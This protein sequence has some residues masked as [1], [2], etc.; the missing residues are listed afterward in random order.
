MS[1][2]SSGNVSIEF[3]VAL[4]MIALV[5]C[6]VVNLTITLLSGRANDQACRDAA[7][8]AA[9]C[10]DAQTALA[11]ARAAAAGHVFFGRTPRIIAEQ[12]SY[13][14]NGGVPL[15]NTGAGPTVRV[16]TAFKADLPFIA[17]FY[18]AGFDT[19][20][21]EFKREYTFPIMKLKES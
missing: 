7:R 8:A 9:Q 5:L 13:D 3:A 20:T 15:P 16:V 6:L 17:R 10:D 19:D 11:A 21:L 4:P 14:T 2:K 18:G 1:R 12:F